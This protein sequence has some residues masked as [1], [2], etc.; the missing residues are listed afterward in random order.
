MLLEELFLILS[1]NSSL[2]EEAL[3]DLH[4]LL[5]IELF[6]AFFVVRHPP[7]RI[8]ERHISLPNIFK[9]INLLGFFIILNI[10]GQLS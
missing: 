1:L 3:E 6:V 5:H 9:G 8:P 4:S 2:M 7:L 10:E